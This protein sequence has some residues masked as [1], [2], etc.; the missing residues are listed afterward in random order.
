M[1]VRATTTRRKAHDHLFRYDQILELYHVHVHVHV[2]VLQQCP[3]TL[4]PCQIGR[5]GCPESELG[6]IYM[7]DSHILAAR[8]HIGTVYAKC[9]GQFSDKTIG[10]RG[11][12]L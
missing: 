5:L 6:E 3:L 9:S 11:L 10:A 4:G 2:H 8:D 7:G 1:V 12:K